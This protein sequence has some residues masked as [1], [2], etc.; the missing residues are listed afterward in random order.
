MVSGI[1][2]A[3]GQE[4]FPDSIVCLGRFF[5]DSVDYGV[6]VN[7][8]ILGWVVVGICKTRKALGRP[9][10]F[11]VQL[12]HHRSGSSEFRIYSLKI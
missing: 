5:D 3:D 1:Y 11:V 9:V 10:H 2:D 8:P 4:Y 6:V 12:K 7:D